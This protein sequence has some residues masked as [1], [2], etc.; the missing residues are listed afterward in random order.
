MVEDDAFDIHG[1]RVPCDRSVLTDLLIKQLSGGWF[2]VDE[3]TALKKI[4]RPSDRVLDVG[5]GLGVTSAVAA[6]VAGV[7]SVTTFEPNPFTQTFL[8]TMFDHNEVTVDLRE[9][10]ILRQPTSEPRDFYARPHIY[11]SSL[12]D[13]GDG[14]GKVVK[15][16]AFGLAEVLTEVRPTVISCDIEGGEIE[17]LTGAAL[18]GVRAV[19]VEVHP[20]IS[21][22]P[23]IDTMLA[24]LAS[25]GLKL[26]PK[27]TTHDVKVLQRSPFDLRRLF[28]R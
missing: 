10:I 28:H 25:I 18:P 27:L 20:D 1:I 24:H 2:E 5:G 26:V 14:S 23:A 6:K 15:V 22:Q 9:G 13:R 21:G 11:G 8:R 7:A 17:L 16:R 4:L 3:V 12:Y 19:I